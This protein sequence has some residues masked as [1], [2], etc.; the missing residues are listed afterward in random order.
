MSALKACIIAWGRGYIYHA[1]AL[2]LPPNVSKKG[3]EKEEYPVTLT[4][5]PE[6]IKNNMPLL[7][8]LSLL[9]EKT[10]LMLFPLS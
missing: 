2:E 8:T 10:L 9:V 5:R 4:S 1:V 7:R 6:S 3:G